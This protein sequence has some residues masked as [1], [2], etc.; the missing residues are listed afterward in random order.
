MTKANSLLPQ[1]TLALRG[2]NCVLRFS[3]YFVHL[4]LWNSLVLFLH[5]PFQYQFPNDVTAT[6]AC[7][8]Q[9][10]ANDAATSHSFSLNIRD[11]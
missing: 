2:E 11:I 1:I 7:S 8:E 9:Q 3:S 5:G 4:F 6:R 10:T